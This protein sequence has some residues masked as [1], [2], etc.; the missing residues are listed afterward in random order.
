[1]YISI[2]TLMGYCFIEL[3]DLCSGKEGRKL[4]FCVWTRALPPGWFVLWFIGWCGV[5]CDWP[6][7]DKPKCQF[8]LVPME[9]IFDRI[10]NC[11]VWMKP[12]RIRQ[13]LRLTPYPEM[14]R[15]CQITDTERL[16]IQ[17]ERKLFCVGLE[18]QASESV[19]RLRKHEII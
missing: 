11:T 1:M 17:Q 12:F 9:Q 19:L 6:V 15:T 7:L 8:L 5:V 2:N 14:L 13:R 16:A 18:D 10:D 3:C 4:L